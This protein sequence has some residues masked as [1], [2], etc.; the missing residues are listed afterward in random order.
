MNVAKK[1]DNEAL[2]G[3]RARIDALDDEIL[4]LIQKRTAVAL[5]IGRLKE[6]HALPVLDLDREKAVLDRLMLKARGRPLKGPAIR[7]IFSAIIR[8]CRGAEEEVKDEPGQP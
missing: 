7:D 2:N 1:K 4:D 3:L 5:E 8:A 6:R